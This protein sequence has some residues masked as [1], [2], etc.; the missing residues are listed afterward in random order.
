MIAPLAET[1]GKA[2]VFIFISNDCPVSNRYAPEIRRL[3]DLFSK[4]GIVFWLVHADSGESEEAIR[5]HAKAYDLP[6]TILLD[7]EQRLVRRLEAKVTPEAVVVAPGGRTVYRGRI[8]NRYVDFGKARRE[9]TERD[10]EEVLVAVA[11][12]QPVAKR[13]APAIGCYIPSLP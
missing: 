12:G 11:A 7:R 2:A 1:G 6:K 5:T 8:D 4:Q 13:N 9:P 10:L 3:H